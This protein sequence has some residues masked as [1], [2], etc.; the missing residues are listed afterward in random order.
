[1]EGPEGAL[2]QNVFKHPGYA[3]LIAK[4]A[5][6]GCKMAPKARDCNLFFGQKLHGAA[7]AVKKMELS[8]TLLPATANNLRDKFQKG[9]NA[10]A[11]RDKGQGRALIGWKRETV[12]K[13]SDKAQGRIGWKP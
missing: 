4:A 5:V 12:S 10:D 11:S 6:I 2:G 9:R 13:R 1:L 7:R 8:G 3:A